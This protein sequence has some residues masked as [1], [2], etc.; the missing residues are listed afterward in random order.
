F[1]YS[2]V[3][4]LGV[5]S[6]LLVLS[7]YWQKRKFNSAKQYFFSNLAIADLLVCIFCMPVATILTFTGN[8]WIFGELLCKLIPFI[9]MLSIAASATSVL[10]ITFER[11]YAIVYPLTFS[12]IFNRKRRKVMISMTWLL[13]G[14][15]AIPK[16][17]ISNVQTQGDYSACQA[18][19]TDTSDRVYIAFGGVTLHALPVF[20]ASSTYIYM[21]YKSNNS[22]HSEQKICVNMKLHRKAMRTAVTVVIVQVISWLPFYI[23]SITYSSIIFPPRNADETEDKLFFVARLFGYANSCWNPLIYA[24]NSTNFRLKF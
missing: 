14:I 20:I 1:C 6:N 19:W 10:A 17:I 24:M 11:L 7:I 22:V 15:Y 5:I 8:D 12:K 23:V 2:A 21:V 3:F 4:I 9:Q 16:L 18:N 13:S